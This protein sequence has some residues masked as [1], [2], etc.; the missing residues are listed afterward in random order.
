MDRKTSVLP[1]KALSNWAPPLLLSFQ[2]VLGFLQL[3]DYFKVVYYPLLGRA[4]STMYFELKF[5]TVLSLSVL[6]VYWMDWMLLNRRFKATLIPFIA[7]IILPFSNI[8]ATIAVASL[9]AVITSLWINSNYT[10][11]ISC[12][13]ITF[14]LIDVLSLFHWLFFVPLGIKSP[15]KEI[16]LIEVGLFYIV[17]HIAPVIIIPFL[18][19]WIKPLLIGSK[20]DGMLKPL[21]TQ[22]KKDKMNSKMKYFLVIILLLGVFSS[23]Y[24]YLPQ[25]NVWERNVGADFMRYV[26]KLESYNNTKEIVSSDKP[27]TFIFLHGIQNIFRLSTKS[28]V[29]LFSSILFLSLLIGIFFLGTE[30]FQNKDSAIWGVFFT[31]CGIQMTVGMYAY[32]LANILALTISFFSL[33]FLFKSLNNGSK[34][35][36]IYASILGGLIVFSHPWTFDQY[37]AAVLLMTG[38]SFFNSMKKNDYTR[39]KIMIVY[40]FVLGISEFLKTYI[41]HGVGGS[42]ATSTALNAISPLS[43][44]WI[45]S[46]YCFRRLYGGSLS[47]IILLVLAL[48]GMFLFNNEKTSEKFFT[49]FFIPSSFLYI[50]SN[51]IIKSRLIYNIP[52]GLFA[53]NSYVSIQN[54]I[55]D[56]NLRKFLGYF[57]VSNF[58]VYLFRTLTNI[59]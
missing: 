20:M 14:T 17:A 23:L 31:L 54:G 1:Q 18:F 3:L 46:L 34:K 10:K 41:F 28:S 24:P 40:T 56:E 53:A 35:N 8:E 50:L 25:I 2:T 52:V 32:F 11:Y 5:S 30:V 37:L 21:K 15:V 27:L 16:A 9:L 42:E 4:T 47:N 49:L 19:I 43:D 12:I 45:Q 13:L 48:L 22:K 33:F 7:L 38:I 39:F 51:G 55:E 6:M 29:L 44:F 36:V 57:I 26:Q 59:V 58:L